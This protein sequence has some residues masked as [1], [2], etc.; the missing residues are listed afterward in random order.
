VAPPV[1]LN[2]YLKSAPIEVLQAFRAR[3]GLS[4][5][6]A[7]NAFAR[8]KGEEPHPGD[9]A[10]LKRWMRYHRRTT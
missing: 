8:F 2:Q 3:K 7:R 10:G 5:R 9:R 6:Q 1:T 4:S